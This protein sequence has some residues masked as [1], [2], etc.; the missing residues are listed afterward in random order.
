M[1]LFGPSVAAPAQHREQLRRLIREYGL[2]I[3]S[4]ALGL[5]TYTVVR[6]QVGS[7][8]SA[9]DRH[10]I[11]RGFAELGPSLGLNQIEPSMALA[12]SGVSERLM[13]LQGKRS[14]VRMVFLIHCGWIPVVQK[15]AS[16]RQG[17][18]IFKGVNLTAYLTLVIVL[19]TG[20]SKRWPWL[21]EVADAL[22]QVA[23]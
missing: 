11:S 15:E 3:V 4:E 16:P 20:L 21:K 2:A 10:A 8:I 13:S 7:K 23:P 9:K 6:Y 5:A 1:R 19:L 14:N 12:I 22:K 17:E 18:F